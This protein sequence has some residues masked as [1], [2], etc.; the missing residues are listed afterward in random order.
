MQKKV[1]DYIREHD[2]LQ[3]GDMVIAAVSGGADSVCMLHLLTALKEELKIRIRVLHIHHGIRGEE[4]DRDAAFVEELSA[5]LGVPCLV[6]RKYVPDYAAEH[7]LSV[8][9]AARILRYQALEEEADRLGGAKI[10]AAHH[11]ADQA[12]TILHNLLRGSSLK[13]LGGMAP[14]REH[15]VRPLLA[16]SREEILAYL[17]ERDLPYCEDSTNASLEYTRNKLRNTIIP[18]L[19]EEVNARAAEHILHAGMLAAQADDYLAETAA[20]ILDQHVRWEGKAG[21]GRIGMDAAALTAQVPIIRT[22]II[23]EMMRRLC[24]SGKDI[25]ARHIAMIETLLDKPVGARADLPYAL[26]ARRTYD[27]LWIENRTFRP[28]VD[29]FSANVLPNPEF[30]RFSF[31][32]HDEIPRNEYTKWFDYDKI[33]GTLSVRFRKTGDYI[34]LKDGSRKMVKSFMIDE[35][36]PREFR[37]KIPLLAE[38]NHVLWIVGYR[39]SE[40]YKITDQTRQILQAKIDGGKDHGR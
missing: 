19:T 25:T 3:D 29:N 13:G 27:A 23:M 31:E 21:E 8:E 22:Y 38:K 11:R 36:I 9:E 33:K 12:E 6:V 4:A 39:I 40:Y 5:A 24:G 37:D 17:K 1:R 35:K 10:A 16:C 14:V 18:L 20:Q 7:G 28:S 2:M 34:T 26:N 15:V 30:T 32:K